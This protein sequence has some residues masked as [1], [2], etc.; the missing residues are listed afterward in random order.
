MLSAWNDLGV[1]ASM[2][3]TAC[4]TD[5]LFYENDSCFNSD[6]TKQKYANAT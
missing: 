4:V 2:H 1:T 6:N 5:G 3:N